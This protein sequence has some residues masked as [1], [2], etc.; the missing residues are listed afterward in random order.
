MTSRDRVI[1][2]I[3]FRGP[4]RVPM[5]HACLPS[6]FAAHPWLPDLLRRFPSDFAGEGAEPPR[7]L[8]VTY[9]RGRYTDAWGCEW[10]MVQDGIIGQVTG[11]PLADLAALDDYHV[12]TVEEEC[13]G[14]A[15]WSSIAGD[16]YRCLGW[17]TLFERMVNLCGFEA[18]LEGLAAGDDR[19]LLLRDR[20]VEHNIALTRV[21]LQYQPDGVFFA[22]D[23]G[24]QQALMIAPSQWRELFLPVYQRQFAPVREVGRHVFF[25][26][27]GVTLP[28]LPDL[29]E[30]GVNVFWADLTLNPL[31][32]LR[33]VLGGKVCFQ[34]LTDVQ[35]L[36]NHG[37]PDAVRRHAREIMSY[38]GT[39]DGGVI[40]C[41]EVAPDQPRENVEAVFATF[42]EEGRYPLHSLSDEEVMR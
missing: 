9:R 1:A 10:T 2:A 19:L 32:E 41:S 3:E 35:F 39:F 23:W 22:D 27:D 33:R 11:H 34:A 28:I 38:L 42:A 7:E 31:P 6:A 26:T 14:I 5:R 13:P 15:D 29:V 30:A 21:L 16:R 25:H 40:A 8:P 20:I 24:T 12:P 37:T 18:L 4:D 17:M 36:I